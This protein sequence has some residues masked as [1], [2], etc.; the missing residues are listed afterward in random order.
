VGASPTTNLPQSVASQTAYQIEQ[1]VGGTVFHKTKTRLVGGSKCRLGKIT[2]TK[3][4]EA[5]NSEQIHW[6]HVVMQLVP[7]MARLDA[8]DISHRR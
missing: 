7:Q 6:A 5:G 4:K 2:G 1:V 8:A 3:G